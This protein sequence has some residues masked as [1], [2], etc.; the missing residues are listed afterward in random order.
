MG[1]FILDGIQFTADNSTLSTAGRKR[2]NLVIQ[3]MG[4][5][6]KQQ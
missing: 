1:Q 4:F 2:L 3:I 6:Y 5:F